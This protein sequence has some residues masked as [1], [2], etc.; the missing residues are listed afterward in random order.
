[1]KIVKG[2]NKRFK[3]IF[4]ND[5]LKKG[6]EFGQIGGK[7]YI[8][9]RTKEERENYLKRHENNPLE[10]K[11]LKNKK[12]YYNSPSVLSAE[13]LWGESKDINKNIKSFKRKYL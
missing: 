9:S 12:K 4:E 11:F 3:A 10:E 6:V 13:I 7:T 2:K 8:D 1:M 5:E